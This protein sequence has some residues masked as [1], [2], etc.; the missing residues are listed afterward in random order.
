MYN[1][2]TN[3]T[4]EKHCKM[5]HKQKAKSISKYEVRNKERKKRKNTDT[6]SFK[7]EQMHFQ[8]D[9]SNNNNKYN[10]VITD[11]FVLLTEIGRGAFGEIYLSFNIRDNIEVAVK[12]EIVIK[13]NKMCSQL[14]NEARIYQHLLSIPSHI[15]LNGECSI[16]QKD[17]QGIPKFYGYG[18]LNDMYDYLIMEFLG[19]NLIELLNYCGYK[20]FTL[21]TVS[22]LALQFLNRIE[23]LHKKSYI[24]RDIKPENFLIGTDNRSN[25]IY[26]LDFGLSKRYKNTKTHQHIPYREGR[27]LVGT[28][29]YVSIN[30][31]LG[32]EQSRRDDLESIGYV[33]VFLLK[34]VLPWQGITCKYNKYTLIME[35]K[36]QIPIEILC[37]GLNDEIS[38]YLNYVRSLKFEDRP[39]YDYLRGLFI[40][41]LNTCTSVYSIIKENIKFDWCFEEQSS[42]WK[43]YNDNK[44][45]VPSFTNDNNTHTHTITTTNNN[46]TCNCNYTSYTNHNN[47]KH[48]QN[49]N[50]NNLEISHSNNNSSDKGQIQDNSEDTIEVEFNGQT[51]AEYFIN[52]INENSSTI[53][54]DKLNEIGKTTSNNI[55]MYIERL[56]Q[57]CILP[58][59]ISIKNIKKTV[60]FEHQYS[61]KPKSS[62][63]IIDKT[64]SKEIDFYT[65]EKAIND[66]HNTNI[67]VNNEYD[68]DINA[69]SYK[70]YNSI[71]N[72]SP[73]HKNNNNNSNINNDASSVMSFE[74]TTH[75]NKHNRFHKINHHLIRD[76]HKSSKYVNIQLAKENL[77]KI[78]KEHYLKY[79]E[80]LNEIGV[81][82][83]GKV[84]KVRHKILNEIR[85]MKVINKKDAST[86]NEIEALRKISHPNILNIFEIFEDNYQYYI[87]SEYCE[88]GELFDAI[89]NNGNY[90]E[91]EAA[92]IMKQILEAV[93][94]LHDN[95]VIHRDLKPENIMLL[96]NKSEIKLIDFG[97]VIQKPKRGKKLTRFIGT[98]Y[99]IAP[100]IIAESYNEKCDIWSCGVILY[101]MLCG[102]PPFYGVT[103][104][105]IYHSIQFTRLI[106]KKD[107]WDDISTEAIQL[108]TAMLDKNPATR[109]SA[110]E[111]LK[112]KWFK[113]CE[114]NNHNNQQYINDND[115]NTFR[116]ENTVI[117]R[118]V[119]I[120][121]QMALFVQQNKFKQAVMQFISTEFNLKKEEEEL[122]RMFKVFDKNSKGT[123][124]RE[125]FIKQLEMLD[126]NV[127]SKELIS[128]IFTMIDLDG[129]GTISYN[130]FLTSIMD[131]K[132]YLTEDRLEKAFRT[133]DKDDNG[134]LSVEE[135]KSVFGGDEK[136]WKKVLKDVDKNGDG[137]VDYNEFKQI[138]IGFD[139]KELVDGNI[140][141]N[142]ECV[143]VE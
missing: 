87:M 130:E 89:T 92:K 52:N 30:T 127:L 115:D 104:K 126:E 61:Y 128:D 76:A 94:Y 95:G 107:E 72:P 6:N 80:V 68:S 112:F 63:I 69:K 10:D 4:K 14:K 7:H 111:C 122:K 79:Y 12:K 57:G 53:K 47:S 24:H 113:L 143:N 97:T 85:A 13:K 9:N 124:S 19:P 138:M 86:S 121:E 38:V 23:T 141:S 99:Y 48:K 73:K 132:K 27:K 106:F 84:K 20:R 78:S 2:E 28:A 29:R 131:N 119:K 77:I 114:D 88:G 42:L 105:E 125:I 123:I 31:H 49:S 56:M 58:K 142:N 133:L 21:V 41:V 25:V 93:N 64:P 39:D 45:N 17:I 117:T 32:I 5:K 44:N 55:E 3:I 101:I 1:N 37:Y 136:T 71:D 35:K 54:Y 40:K 96:S 18:K 103:N 140:N 26:L 129:S 98:T 11:N 67:N 8:H 90:D 102:Y 116:R 100:E 118:K 83:Y 137:E 120:I 33:I 46:H 22:L 66:L 134:Y 139:F 81:G 70:H 36:L 34:G 51:T 15:T 59:E 108:I 65:I 62:S 91:I 110:Y 43:M 135:I 74:H 60:T 109:P 50:E 75:K 82:S 16:P